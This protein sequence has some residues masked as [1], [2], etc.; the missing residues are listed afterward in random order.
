MK[1]SLTKHQERDGSGESLAM[2]L[3]GKEDM[4]IFSFPDR[5]S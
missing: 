4:Y 1:I 2:W 3:A 5:Q